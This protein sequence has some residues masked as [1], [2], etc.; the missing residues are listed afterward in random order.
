MMSSD[1][2]VGVNFP[3][4]AMASG[5]IDGHIN[6]L[7]SPSNAIKVTDTIPWVDS[8]AATNTSPITADTCN[9][10]TCEIYLGIQIMP[11]TYPTSMQLNVILVKEFSG[12]QSDALRS[13]IA[14]D[15]VAG[16]YFHAYIQKQREHSEQ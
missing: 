14:D 9:T 3:N 5:Q 8:A 15:G 11:M 7:G 16:D 4:P 1:E 10:F 13:A 2:P 12:R 6:E